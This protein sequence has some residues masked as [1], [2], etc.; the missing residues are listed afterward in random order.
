[1]GVFVLATLDSFGIP[2]PGGTDF[3]IFFIAAKSPEQAYWTALIALI[4]SLIGNM[5]LF[6][7]ARGGGKRFINTVPDPSKPQ[8]FRHWF[9]RYGMV[10][11]FIPAMLPFPPL[12]LKVFVISAALLRTRFRQFLGVVLL[13]RVIRYGGESYLGIQLGEDGAQV[14][15]KHNAFA[16]IGVALA[17]A[18]ALGLVV[19]LN[20]RRKPPAPAELPVE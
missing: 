12:P 1:M 9:G 18:L 19:K 6:S 20:D 11:V 7:A 8:R 10:T 15:L 5:A 4:G 2:I 14:F 13:A 3:L 17:L 16:L